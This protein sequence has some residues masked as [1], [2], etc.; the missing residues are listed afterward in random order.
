MALICP[1]AKQP[2]IHMIIATQLNTQHIQS[3]FE[4]T[5]QGIRNTATQRGAKASSNQQPAPTQTRQAAHRP[6]Q[7]TNQQ[8]APNSPPATHASRPGHPTP[9][10]KPQPGSQQGRRERGALKRHSLA[11]MEKLQTD[12]N[13]RDARVGTST[14]EICSCKLERAQHA[15]RALHGLFFGESN[16]L[17][18]ASAPIA[19]EGEH[20]AF[21]PKQLL[22]RD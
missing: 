9:P 22:L 17:Q 6:D 19:K 21:E 18:S 15:L 13:Y 4:K 2:M 5:C 16:V 1:N 8:T 14:L 7:P 20:S 3:G 10:P 11:R 12:H